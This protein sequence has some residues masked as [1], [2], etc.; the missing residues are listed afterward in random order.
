MLFA[1]PRAIV[2]GI[3]SAAFGANLLAALNAIKAGRFALP[4]DR[5]EIWMPID[6]LFMGSVVSLACLLSSQALRRR[7]MERWWAYGLIG[8]SVGSVVLMAAGSADRPVETLLASGFGGVTHWFIRWRTFTPGLHKRLITIGGL[9]SLL[10]LASSGAGLFFQADAEDHAPILTAGM[11]PIRA[12]ATTRALWLMMDENTL[13]EHDLATQHSRHLNQK[14]LRALA[15]ADDTVWALSDH[16][17][18]T[19][20]SSS[21]TPYVSPSGTIELRAYGTNGGQKSLVRHHDS[22]DRPVAMT[23]VNGRPLILTERTILRL[24]FD[25]QWRVL[26]WRKPASARLYDTHPWPQE[27]LTTFMAAA[28]AASSAAALFS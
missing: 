22:G 16:L 7:K 21:E 27:M 4:A 20:S 3:A 10:L 14:D 25:G 23:L 26:P 1:V 13:V 24:A 6:L 12:V 9:A 8:I 28:M 18:T 11:A 19:P 17:D 15:A 2:C 5:G